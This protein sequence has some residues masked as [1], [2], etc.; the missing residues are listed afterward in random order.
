MTVVEVPV[1]VVI[2]VYELCH[3]F[4]ASLSS[5]IDIGTPN[6][7]YDIAEDVVVD[8]VV[9]IAAVGLSLCDLK[10]V[11]H[12]EQCDCKLITDVL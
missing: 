8:V 9:V 7:G 4:F 2:V 1:F 5:A 3:S 12:N 10:L 11:F 6:V